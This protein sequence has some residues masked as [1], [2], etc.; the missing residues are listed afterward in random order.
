MSAEKSFLQAICETPEDDAPRLV[1]AD[2]LEDHGDAVRAE[3]I[4]TQC[5]LAA[6]SP[7]D[8]GYDELA[9]RAR[10]LSDEHGKMWGKPVAKFTTNVIF[11]RG[12]VDGVIMTARKFL[13]VA[14]GLFAA[15]P[16]QSLCPLQVRKFWTQL[17]AS[18]H[19]SR[20]R[21]LDLESCA[22]G[23]GR[24]DSVAAC[25]HLADLREL[26]VG[27][28]R[29]KRG[30]V[31]VLRSTM[32]GN[33]RRLSVHKNE[34]TDAAAEALAEADRFPHLRRL[35]LASNELTADGARRLAAAAWLGRLEELRLSGNPI[36]DEGV[37]ALAASEVWTGLRTLSLRGCGLTQ[38]SARHVAACGRLARLRELSLPM[39]PGEGALGELARSPHLVELRCL[40]LKSTEVSEADA[41]A[42]VRSPL[43]PR[44][45]SLKLA[46]ASGAV[47]KVVL[48]ARSLSGLTGLAISGRRAS[49][50]DGVVGKWLREAA[51]LENLTHLDVS[52]CKLGDADVAELA[53]CPHFARLVALDLSSNAVTAAGF[54]AL[55]ES[56]HL[57]ALKRLGAGWV[58]EPEVMTLLKA[59]FG[60][61]RGSL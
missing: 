8:D 7:W 56:P 25:E 21:A 14:D 39:S 36:R 42:L 44:L 53:R 11:R 50:A 60:T 51:H 24:T 2:W 54:R 16:L 33:L 12:F 57:N 15:A 46:D 26:N 5:R 17:I 6:M 13:D 22:L 27:S 52:Y 43:A 45:R 23:V 10:Q 1:F 3:F 35:D 38:A 32:L 41:D 61:V 47:Q 58:L 29:A 19:L 48:S 59:R 9:E 34:V 20:L 55:A 49:P 30:A 31:A 18:P 40:D 28:N 4:R 37:E